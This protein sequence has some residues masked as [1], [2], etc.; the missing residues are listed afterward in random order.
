MNVLQVKAAQ[1]R[2]EADE[3]VETKD[4]AR[5]ELNALL[6]KIKSLYLQ[7]TSANMKSKQY[8]E[9]PVESDVSEKIEARDTLEGQGIDDS[10][11]VDFKENLERK[12]LELLMLVEYI[13]MKVKFILIHYIF[14]FS[15]LNISEMI[16]YKNDY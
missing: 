10:N 9:E 3:S 4:Q 11:A 12:I 8:I 14:L 13:R 1:S 2:S 7:S 15:L 16:S 5:G 6:E